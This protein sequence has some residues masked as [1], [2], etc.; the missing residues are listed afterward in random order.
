MT[1]LYDQTTNVQ[2]V[3]TMKETSQAHPPADKREINHLIKQSSQIRHR[4]HR[5]LWR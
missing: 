3:I 5:S 4:R 1:V 2:G